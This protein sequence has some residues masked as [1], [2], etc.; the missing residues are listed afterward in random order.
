MGRG[1][2]GQVYLPSL[3]VHVHLGD[4]DAEHCD[5]FVALRIVGVVCFHQAA[6]TRNK[7]AQAHRGLSRRGHLSLGEA[8]FTFRPA[9]HI[10]G[11]GDQLLF[12][13]LCSA[14]HGLAGHVGHPAAA[15]TGLEGNVV[16]APVLQVDLIVGHAQLLAQYLTQHGIETGA[17]VGQSG[18]ERYYAIG[19]YGYP[20][21][22]ASGPNMPLAEGHAPA[23]QLA[24]RSGFGVKG[25]HAH[26]VLPF[27]AQG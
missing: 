11:H 8:R 19:V 5:V 22:R 25:A 27:V 17:G 24:G 26:D 12:Q 1:E 14:E 10:R 4:L 18:I 23:R 3:F 20:D 6:G 7:V 9:E 2:L 15:H 13:L 16:G 21:C